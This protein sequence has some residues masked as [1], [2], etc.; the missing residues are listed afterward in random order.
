MLA[1]PKPSAGHPDLTGQIRCN[2][3]RGPLQSALGASQD[4]IDPRAK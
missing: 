2:P 1:L 4:A 3:L